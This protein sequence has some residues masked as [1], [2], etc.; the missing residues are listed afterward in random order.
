MIK[1]FCDKCGKELLESPRNV[2][3]IAIHD[4][5]SGKYRLRKKR[6]MLCNIHYLEF[7]EQFEINLSATTE[8]TLYGVK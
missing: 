6:L 3:N 2:V 4:E 8:N 5:M 7:A 1:Y